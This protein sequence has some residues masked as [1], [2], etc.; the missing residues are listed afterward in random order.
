MTTYRSSGTRTRLDVASLALLLTGISS[1]LLA[2]WLIARGCDAAL[3]IPAVVASTL[4]A[5]HLF[6]R[7]APRPDGSTRR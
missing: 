7:E 2:Y 1:G 3:L 6:K 4:G 5:T